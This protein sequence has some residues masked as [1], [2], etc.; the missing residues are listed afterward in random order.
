[1]MWLAAQ[2]NRTIKLRDQWGDI[3]KHNLKWADGMVGCMPV[4][5]TL[6]AVKE[7]CRVTGSEVTAFEVEP[8]GRPAGRRPYIKL[9]R[10]A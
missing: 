5:E 4:F 1:M 2:L 9:V 10:P 8:T 3:T 7:Y 6:E